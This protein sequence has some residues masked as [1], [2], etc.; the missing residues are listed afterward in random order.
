MEQERSRLGPLQYGIILLTLTTAL[1]HISLLFPDTL[2]IL[3]GLGFLVLL[4]ALYLPIAQLR[5]Y[6]GMVRWLL[7]AY[8]A[9]TLIIWIFIGSR[10]TW[11]TSQN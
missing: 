6:Q 3:N 11:P 8:T 2:F 9:V 10:T 5:P 7:I 1:I 4:A